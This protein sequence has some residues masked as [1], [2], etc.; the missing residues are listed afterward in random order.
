MSTQTTR[1]LTVPATVYDKY[2]AAAEDVAR[3][4]P[5]MRAVPLPKLTQLLLE[6]ELDRNSSR[7]IAKRFVKN[8]VRRVRLE[9]PEPT[10]PALPTPPPLAKSSVS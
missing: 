8:I 4:S 1:T 10:P 5:L 6:V 3:S 7:D 2:V 9:A